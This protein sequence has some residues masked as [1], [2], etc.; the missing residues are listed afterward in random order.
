[1]KRREFIAGIG[2]AAAWPFHSHAQQ[3]LPVIGFL[4][5]KARADPT[6]FLPLFRRG[7]GDAGYIE[8]RNVTLEYRWADGD[9]TRLP[10]MAADLAARKVT[11]I[12]AAGGDVVALAAKAATTTIPIV[13]STGSDPIKT[14]LVSSIS[15][16]EGNVTG[17]SLF[18]G[19]LDAKRVE[20]LHEMAPQ[21]RLIAV[22]QNPNLAEAGR[23][24]KAIEAAA[25]A[26]G[27]QAF[28]ADASDEATIDSAFAAI[29]DRR[30][31]AVLV[32][33]DPFLLSHHQQI[34]ALVARVAIP[35]IYAWSEYVK[36]GG[37]MSYG[38]NLANATRDMG[39]YAGK[40]L[41][42]VKPADLPVLQP[43]KFELIVNL[44]TA[45]ALGISVPATLIAGA[46]EV[47]E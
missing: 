27:M 13:F 12:V 25:R 16:P 41:N 28:G 11:V 23:R 38:V 42:G 39:L 15:R 10:T 47:I 33:G 31:G 2:L 24:F 14:G 35:A 46:D 20:M 1:M 29:A 7:L 22:L 43:T 32:A 37:L 30:A 8:G 44:T 34:V 26:L 3:N 6:N 9:Y 21:V 17:I 36:A 40:I 18:N 5:S 19:E 4:H 45:K